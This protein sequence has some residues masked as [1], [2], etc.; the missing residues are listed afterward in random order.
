MGIFARLA[1]L[2]KSNINALISDSE[3]PE[4]MLTQLIR[5]MVE[6][7]GVAKRQVAGAIA[8]EK[9]LARQAEGERKIAEDWEK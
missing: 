7:L 4:K 6:Q 9:R 3:D 1:R 5:D 8:D 2:I